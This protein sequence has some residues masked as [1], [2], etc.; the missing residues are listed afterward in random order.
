MKEVQVNR[1]FRGN[2]YEITVHNLCG[3]EKGKVKL[4]VDGAPLSGQTIPASD[5]TGKT[6]RVEVTV[7]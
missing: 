1:V 5:E 2:E 4:S 7:Q 3:G 6:Y